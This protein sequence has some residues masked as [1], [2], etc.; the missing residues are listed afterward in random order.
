MRQGGW[1]GQRRW[2]QLARC[3]EFAAR[4]DG[5]AQPQRAFAAAPG[6]DG[7]PAVLSR[8][9]LAAASG[10]ARFGAAPGRAVPLLFC[11]ARGRFLARDGL[12]C[13]AGTH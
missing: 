8:V 3:G 4:R 1:I 13:D 5:L 11:D 9:A 12:P 10:R 7:L 2:T 6:R